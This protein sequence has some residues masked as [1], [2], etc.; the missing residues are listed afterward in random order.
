MKALE[1]PLQEHTNYG[2]EVGKILMWLTDLCLKNVIIQY[3]NK[4]FNQKDRNI[5]GDNHSISLANIALHYIVCQ[6]STE[7]QHTEIFKH[8]IDDIAWYSFGNQ[9]THN[10]KTKL[11][12][13]FAKYDLT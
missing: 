10:I 5:T 8:F 1:I 3:Q 2:K 9:A 13:T 7:V 12:E 11:A 6:V 4:F